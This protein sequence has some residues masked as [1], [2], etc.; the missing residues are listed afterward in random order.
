VAA[1]LAVAVGTIMRQSA[2]AIAAVIG[3]MVVTYFFG[4]ALPV[5]PAG[6]ADWVLRL[7]PAAGFAI[8]QYVPAY[9]QVANSYTPQFG[10]F[11]LVPWAGF[12]VSCLWAVIAL[13]LATVL[14]RRRDA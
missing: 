5:L 1:V 12:G 8:Q 7:T 14:L 9:A 4:A 13:A 11:P 2:G 10:Y 3:L 6:V